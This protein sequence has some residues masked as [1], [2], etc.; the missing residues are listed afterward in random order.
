MQVS[1]GVFVPS[2]DKWLDLAVYASREELLT[3]VGGTVFQRYDCSIRENGSALRAMPRNAK[4]HDVW[5]IWEQFLKAEKMGVLEPFIMYA[6]SG[7]GLSNKNFFEA[8]QGRY[9][10][11]R[12]FFLTTLDTVE[13]RERAQGYTD[14]VVHGLFAEGYTIF[15]GYVFYDK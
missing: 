12:E 5:S 14:D 15:D 9:A 11:E 2:M 3:A 1:I 4:L 7:Y 6:T 10:S 8:Y 13:E